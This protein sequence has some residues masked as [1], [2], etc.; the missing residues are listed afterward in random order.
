VSVKAT[1][2]IYSAGST[3]SGTMGPPLSSTSA[4]AMYSAARTFRRCCVNGSTNPRARRFARAAYRRLAA[5]GGI[6]TRRDGIHVCPGRMQ[7]AR[8][9]TPTGT[10]YLSTKRLLSHVAA[11]SFGRQ[12]R[13]AEPGGAP[14]AEPAIAKPDKYLRSR[15]VSHLSL[16]W[17]RLILSL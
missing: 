14:R 5:L 6:L 17:P 3:S 12:S 10:P 16:S 8:A 1:V 2:Q 7:S 15:P 9:S 11:R 13:W 4:C